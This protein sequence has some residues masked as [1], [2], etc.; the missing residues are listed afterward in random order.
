MTLQ[1]TRVEGVNVV[2][3]VESLVIRAGG[4]GLMWSVKVTD[5]GLRVEGVNAVSKGDS[6]SHESWRG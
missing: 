6:P 3:Y 2:F 4:G 5:Q 1:I